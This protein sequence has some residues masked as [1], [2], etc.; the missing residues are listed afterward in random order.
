[1][2]CVEGTQGSLGYMNN[3]W[4]I[5]NSCRARTMGVEPF[6]RPGLLSSCRLRGHA[7]YE[8]SPDSR[9]VPRVMD[10]MIMILH[11]T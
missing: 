2:A 9:V 8:C 3:T 7:T 6:I 4:L 10:A 1:M 11:W 5:A